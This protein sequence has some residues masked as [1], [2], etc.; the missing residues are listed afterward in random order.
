MT[1]RNF[2]ERFARAWAEA[3]NDRDLDAVMANYADD[4]VFYSPRI[5]VLLGEGR[6]SI[7]G[8]AALRDYWEAALDAAPS[9]YLDAS[10]VF[11]GSESVTILY[12]NHRDE[13]VA[14]TFIFNSSR[15]VSVSVAAYE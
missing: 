8:K 7:S 13:S 14:E 11:V 12:T 10:R 15:L 9:V 4:V 3:W 2:A 1:D 5:A 6:E